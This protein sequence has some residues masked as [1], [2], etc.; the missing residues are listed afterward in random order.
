MRKFLLFFVTVCTFLI[1]GCAD[2]EDF[3]QKGNRPDPYASLHINQDEALDISQKVM[4]HSPT[5]RSANALASPVFSYVTNGASTRY[6]SVSDF[7]AKYLKLPDI[8]LSL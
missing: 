5:T 6:A 7:V 3:Q 4:K 2:S 1:M 8:D